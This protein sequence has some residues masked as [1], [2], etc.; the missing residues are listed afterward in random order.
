L[1]PAQCGNQLSLPNTAF[2]SMLSNSVHK[3]DLR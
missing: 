3:I 2:F 1:R